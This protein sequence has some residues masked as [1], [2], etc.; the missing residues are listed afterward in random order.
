MVKTPLPTTTWQIPSLCLEYLFK[1]RMS[2]SPSNDEARELKEKAWWLLVREKR[3]NRKK[4]LT[5]FVL[6]PWSG[7]QTK[8]AGLHTHAITM[9]VSWMKKTHLCARQCFCFVKKRHQSIWFCHHAIWF[10]SP[11]LVEHWHS[12]MTQ[13]SRIQLRRGAFEQINEAASK[14]N[15]Y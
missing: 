5:E 10:I 8:P 7:N 14:A 9:R 15:V 1:P 11:Y 6:A 3:M 13:E 12:S 2:S 4:V